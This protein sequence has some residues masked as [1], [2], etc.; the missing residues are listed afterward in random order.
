MK[1]IYTISAVITFSISTFSHAENTTPQTENTLTISVLEIKQP[2]CNGAANGSV[3]VEVKGGKLPYQYN[4]NTFPAQ[5]SPQAINLSKGIYFIQVTD[6]AGVVS[7]Q[8]I[9][10]VDPIQTQVNPIAIS[11]LV[12]QSVTVI[13]KNENT[14]FVYYLD[15][16]QITEPI[17]TGLDIGIHKLTIESDHS[18]EIIVSE[19]QVLTESEE[20]N[21]ITLVRTE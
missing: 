3:L 1:T 13:S 16:K 2:T 15:G 8:S 14:D 19:L 9:E 17:V 11:S 20:N 21:S 4:W 10:L 7:Y 5:S 18:T 6:A 12:S